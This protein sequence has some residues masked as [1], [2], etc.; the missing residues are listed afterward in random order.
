MIDLAIEPVWNSLTEPFAFWNRNSIKMEMMTKKCWFSWHFWVEGGGKY[1]SSHFCFFKVKLFMWL[2]FL[3]HVIIS[4]TKYKW[5]SQWNNKYTF[6]TEFQNYRLYHSFILK[7][8]CYSQNKIYILYI[9]LFLSFCTYMYF[10]IQI[11]QEKA[12][13]TK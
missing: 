8:G 6:T 2:F 1:I 7:S 5:Q 4:K 13:I 12:L 9:T 10:Y 3:S 11:G